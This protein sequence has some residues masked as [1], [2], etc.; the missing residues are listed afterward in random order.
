MQIIDI[1]MGPQVFWPSAVI[2]RVS[3]VKQIG[4]TFIKVLSIIDSTI[5]EM[6]FQIFDL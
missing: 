1:Y 3:T 2:F 4:F 5:I 6:Q